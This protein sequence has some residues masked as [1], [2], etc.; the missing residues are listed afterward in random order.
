[1]ARPSLALITKA[2]ERAAAGVDYSSRYG[3][4]CPWCGKRTRIY[5]TTPWEG[6]TRIRYHLCEKPGCAL[7]SMRATIKSIE[8]E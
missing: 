2:A 7:S 5:K 3:C 4:R 8:T 1:M 6:G